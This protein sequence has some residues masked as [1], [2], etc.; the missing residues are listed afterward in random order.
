M[1]AAEQRELQEMAAKLEATAGKLPAGSSRDELIKD[2]ARFRAQ[3]A[4]LQPAVLQGMR[5]LIIVAAVCFSSSA[6]AQAPSPP[7][8][9]QKKPTVQVRPKALEGCKLVGTVKGTK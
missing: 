7:K 9:S 4:A 1:R 3:I 8:A 5:F 6:M 2:I